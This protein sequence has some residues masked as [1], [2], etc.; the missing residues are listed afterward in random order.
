MKTCTACKQRKD[1]SQ[2]NKLSRSAD[3]L[4]GKCKQCFSEYNK[5]H[6]QRNAE[7]KKVQVM[8]R[9]KK[10]GQKAYYEASR[11]YA[12]QYYQK[13][14]EHISKRNAEYA[15]NNREV[16]R[17][18]KARY[19]AK[20]VK[21]M[22]K[23]DRQKSTLHRKHIKDD[24]CFYCK[25]FTPVMHDDHYYPLSKGGTDHWFNLVRSCSTCN[26]KKN[27]RLASTLREAY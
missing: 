24:P 20:L 14:K 15:K 27:S 21:G 18:I 22:S 23:I 10:I 5:L 25:G 7:K 6:Y 8:E 11:S 16:R 2:F 4:Q 13:N 17:G 3:G 19:R 12:Q 26:Q 9:Y 1:L